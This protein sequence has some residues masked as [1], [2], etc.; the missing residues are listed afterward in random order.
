MPAKP[1]NVSR[2]TTPRCRQQ[3]HILEEIGLRLHKMRRIA[4][5]T[6]EFDLASAKIEELNGQLIELKHE[7]RYLEK[8]LQSVVY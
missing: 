7:V 6:L 2:T 8:Q 4:E 1:K 3:D 5:Y